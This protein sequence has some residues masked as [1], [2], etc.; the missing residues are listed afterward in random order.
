MDTSS[1]SRSLRACHDALLDRRCAPRC[2]HALSLRYDTPVV[3]LVHVINGDCHGV[4]RN[5]SSEWEG[6]G[7][8][9]EQRSHE[10]MHCRHDGMGLERTEVG[11]QCVQNRTDH[12]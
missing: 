10:H 3:C 1:S 9:R 12:H 2:A 11:G 8:R 5:V 7:H 4:W 6:G